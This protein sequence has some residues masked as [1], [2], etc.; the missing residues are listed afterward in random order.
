M[1]VF[2]KSGEKDV[3]PLWI[4]G[5]DQPV[6]SSQHIEVIQ[7]VEDKIVYYAQSATIE[8]AEDAVTAATTAFPIWSR[9]PL[10]KRR[11][12]LLKAADLLTLRAQ[13]LGEMQALETSAP[14]QSGQRFSIGGAATVQEIATQI[15]TAFEGAFPFSE[16]DGTYLMAPSF[17]SPLGMDQL[18][19]PH[20]VLPLH[21][22][23][24]ARS[25]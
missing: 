9:T 10:T 21:L 18:I 1:P 12:I 19:W 5:K 4:S 22:P 2:Q 13:E 23:L 7:A 15:T 16:N 8:D 6:D 14:A 20:A 25:Y 24:V 17:S 3:V 11:E